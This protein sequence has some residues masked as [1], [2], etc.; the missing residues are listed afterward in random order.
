MTNINHVVVIGNLTR[1]VGEGFGYI[2]N[3]TAR[4]NVTVAVNRS[5]KNGD[6]WTDEVSFFDVVIWGNTAENLKPYLTKGQKI[7]VDGWLKQERWEKDGQ[8]NS[9]V[10]IQADRVELLGG[11][12]KD[13]E[14]NNP[15]TI[16]KKAGTIKDA[17]APDF[18][19]SEDIPF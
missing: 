16:Q 15:A 1:D 2:G 9:R 11:R 6:E 18:I 13:I 3:G 17:P 5:R 10:T 12:E 19:E 14:G 7:A 4:A 8:K